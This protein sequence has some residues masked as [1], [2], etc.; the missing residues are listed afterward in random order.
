MLLFERATHLVLTGNLVPVDTAL[1]VPALYKSIDPST[2]YHRASLLFP[3][4]SSKDLI[5]TNAIYFS[6]QRRH[7]SPILRGESVRR[8]DLGRVR[9]FLAHR[10]APSVRHRVSHAQIQGHQHQR[11]RHG[12]CEKRIFVGRSRADPLS[13]TRVFQVQLRRRSDGEVSDSKQFVYMPIKEGEMTKF[14]ALMVCRKTKAG[15]RSRCCYSDGS[16]HDAVNL[17]SIA[18]RSSKL[19]DMLKLLQAAV[20]NETS[21]RQSRATRNLQLF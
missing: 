21:V 20:E 7:P 10:R 2:F 18:S 3:V 17:Y 14:E 4:T 1:T 15:R 5:V 9:G 11:A 13:T 16:R 6:N 19:L 8:R 12:E